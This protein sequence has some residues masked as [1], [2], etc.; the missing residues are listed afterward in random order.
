MITLLVGDNT[1]EIERFIARLTADFAGRPERIDGSMLEP[2]R[3]ADLVAGGTLFADERLV[4][5]RELSANTQIWPEI[6]EWA[7]RVSADTHLVLS[8]SKP[9]KRTRAY[10][11]ITQ[12]ANVTE[13]KLWTDKDSR[14]AEAWVGREAEMLGVSLDKKSIQHLVKRVGVDQ[15][16]L[17]RAL[18]KL[19]LVQNVTTDV[20][21][22][23]VEPNPQES[24]FVLFEMALRG[25]AAGISDAVATLRLSEDPYR[26]FGLLVSQAFNLAALATADGSADVAKDFSIHP[27]AVSKLSRDARRLG[28]RGAR[29]V[30]EIL[31]KADDDLKSSGADPWQLIERALLDSGQ[32]VRRL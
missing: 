1:F 13:L 30:I 10:K 16:S 6:A 8:E 3:F 23:I 4:I 19:A 11:D 24:V 20:I 9:D 12:I 5:I 29:K 32:I 15:W 21:D 22:S 2:H 27:Y 26:T 18:E 31:G 25:D 14:L 28:P 7:K 17:Y